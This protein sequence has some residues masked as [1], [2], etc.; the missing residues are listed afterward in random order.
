MTD[1]KMSDL[2]KASLDGVKSFTDMDTVM[3]RA[4]NTPSGVT[5]IPISKVT[6]GFAGGGVD[7]GGKKLTSSQNFGGGSGTGVSITPVA[8]LTVGKNA[9]VNLIP[10][11]NVSSDI[12]RITGLI[13]KSPEIIERIKNA[14]T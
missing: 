1:N 7:Y 4:I 10:L 8:F 6:V 12:E 14:L 5:V 11:G 9:E 2:I 13:D 3:G